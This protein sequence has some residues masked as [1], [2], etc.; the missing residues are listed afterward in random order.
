MFFLLR[1]AV[2]ITLVVLALPDR[3]SSHDASARSALATVRDLC[4]ADPH[5]C[6]GLVSDHVAA[7]LPDPAPPQ[8]PRSLPSMD[9]LQ[10]DDLRHPWARPTR[11]ARN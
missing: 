7:L 4:R 11:V 8:V 1:S 9:T 5:R 3:T 10:P 6:L 2:C